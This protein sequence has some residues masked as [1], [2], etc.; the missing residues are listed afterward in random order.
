MFLGSDPTHSRTARNSAECSEASAFPLQLVLSRSTHERIAAAKR[1]QD[2]LIEQAKAEAVAVRHCQYEELRAFQKLRESSAIE[3]RER[4]E[5]LRQQRLEDVQQRVL[6]FEIARAIKQEEADAE[7]ARRIEA[8]TQ[9]RYEAIRRRQAEQD[10]ILAEHIAEEEVRLEEERRRTQEAEERE[11]IR[12]ERLRECAA[13]MEEDDMG[14]MTQAPCTHWYCNEHLQSE[15]HQ[16]PV[17]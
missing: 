1:T 5:S 17:E 8:E 16:M 11:R 4:E 6:A 15:F 3:K 2:G 13:C 10:R 9:A 7:I 12:R 14:S